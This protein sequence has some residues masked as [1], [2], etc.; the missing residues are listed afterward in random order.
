MT[1]DYLFHLLHATE[2]RGPSALSTYV[3]DV[4]EAI[5]RCVTSDSLGTNRSLELYGPQVLSLGEIVRA[6]RAAAG[7]RTLIV[8]LPDSLGRLQVSLRLL[9]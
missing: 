5:A 2:S 3:G 8:P 4:V 7:R 1:S 9:A 6:I